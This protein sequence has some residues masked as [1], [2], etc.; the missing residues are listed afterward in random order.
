MDNMDKKIVD[1]AS[2]KIERSLKKEG[3][4]IKMDEKKKVKLLIKIKR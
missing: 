1:F 3:Y 4:T 2:F